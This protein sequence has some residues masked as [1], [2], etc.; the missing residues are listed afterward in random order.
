LG[1][2]VGLNTGSVAGAYTTAFVHGSAADTGLF[3]GTNSGVMEDVYAAGRAGTVA[4]DMLTGGTAALRGFYDYF[5]AG[6]GRSQTTPSIALATEEMFAMRGFAVGE[7]AK[8]IQQPDAYPQLA[9]LTNLTAQT[10]PIE[11]ANPAKGSHTPL[12]YHI[13]DA[14]ARVAAAGVKTAYGQFI[15]TL[16]LGTAAQNGLTG[17]PGGGW[18]SAVPGASLSLDEAGFAALAR[19]GNPGDAIPEASVTA[20][21]SVPTSPWTADAWA[22]DKSI[23]IAAGKENPV[24]KPP[25]G[26]FAA[27]D[28]S[29]ANPYIILTKEQFNTLR[30]YGQVA[31][32][33]FVLKQDIDFAGAPPLAVIPV[34]RSSLDGGQH[35]IYNFTNENNEHTGLFEQ[36]DGV[37]GVV[38]NLGIVGAS[39]AATADGNRNSFGLI[40]GRVTNGGQIQ[41][42]FASGSLTVT[43]DGLAY[44]GGVAGAVD[45]GAALTGVVSSGRVVNRSQAAGSAVGGVAGLAVAATL[46]NSLST[47]FVEGCR[48]IGGIAGAAEAASLSGCVFAGTALDEGLRETL[49]PGADARIG[50]IAGA[51]AGT[52][53]AGCFYDTA[54]AAVGDQNGAGAETQAL[55]DGTLQNYAIGFALG[56]ASERFMK[57]LS[58]ATM[59]VTVTKNGRPA[60]LFS[61]DELRV[62]QISSTA[63]VTTTY[64]PLQN[65]LL[66]SGGG[67][68]IFIPSDSPDPE[69][70][71]TGM[72]AAITLAGVAAGTVFRYFEPRC[73]RIIDVAYAFAAGPNVPLGTADIL[74]LQI[75]NK[76]GVLNMSSE[77]FS[78]IGADTS[79][80]PLDSLAVLYTKADMGIYVGAKLPPGYRYR[81]SWHGVGQEGAPD[82]PETD[83]T[84]TENEYGAFVDISQWTQSDSF[85]LTVTVEKASSWGVTALWD[86]LLN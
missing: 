31:D 12:K 82:G 24:Y 55:L 61:F 44:V 43:G 32:A 7:D 28:G 53:F 54:L 10:E 35:V 11:E 47:A 69:N 13:L 23:A 18:S 38:R 68:D 57:A 84:V 85:F 77:T 3:A 30:L 65:L 40:A 73:V 75:K 33:H 9:A 1:G 36:I 62:P 20:T 71:R 63:A 26:G 5:A 67:Y 80:K 72:T 86:S 4:D 37:N 46:Q 39:F 49:R 34:L 79:Q 60:T 8:F 16:A 21:L 48:D 74:A 6:S 41:D 78:F 45:G 64:A 22:V 70:Y 19:L 51:A 29:V 66:S 76:Y 25:E 14:Y 83:A 52:A 2:F 81:V 42:S 56:G 15:D 50:S 59:P 58:L 17:L 27:G